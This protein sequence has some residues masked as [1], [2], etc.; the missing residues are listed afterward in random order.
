[1]TPFCQAWT[2]AGFKT[3]YYQTVHA[4]QCCL[5]MARDESAIWKRTYELLW[6][7]FGSLRWKTLTRNGFGMRSFTRSKQKWHP[8]YCSWSPQA[9]AITGP[10]PLLGMIL[11]TSSKPRAGLQLVS[12]AWPGVF[13]SAVF[14]KPKVL[15]VNWS[16][17]ICGGFGV[18]LKGCGMPV[19]FLFCHP[20]FRGTTATHMVL[21]C[22]ELVVGLKWLGKKLRGRKAS[23]E[24]QTI[25][26]KSWSYCWICK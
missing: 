12:C 20:L 1:M 13:M 3:D 15:M 17:L 21:E 6:P 23:V 22:Q 18:A 11:S 10:T 19:K 7:S 25:Y 8:T 9:A 26:A 5:A 16:C 14:F 4:V 2:D 24:H